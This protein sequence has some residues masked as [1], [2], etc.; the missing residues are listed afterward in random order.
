MIAHNGDSYTNNIYNMI[1]LDDYSKEDIK[2]NKDRLVHMCTNDNNS[3]KLVSICTNGNNTVK[4]V[5][6]CTGKN[7]NNIVGMCTNDYKID[8]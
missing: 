3:D 7:T 5:S 6:I 1:Y 8:R 4:L 2:K